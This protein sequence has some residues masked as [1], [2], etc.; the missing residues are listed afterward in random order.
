MS[1][2]NRAEPRSTTVTPLP[3]PAREVKRLKTVLLFGGSFD[4]PHAAHVAAAV[5]ARDRLFGEGGWVLFV[6]AARSPHKTSGTTAG[7]RERAEMVRL[8]VGDQPRCSVWT[9]ELDRANAAASRG[10]PAASYTIDTVRR[11]RRTLPSKI[12][13][14]VIIGAD[15]A[16][17]FHRWKDAR[18]LIALARPVVLPREP[19]AT[20]DALWNALQH[21]G[22]WKI[23]ELRAWCVYLAPTPVMAAS[24]TELRRAL[25]KASIARAVRLGLDRTVAEYIREHELYRAVSCGPSTR[26]R[27]RAERSA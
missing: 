26:R 19:I 14:R 24:S 3:I 4:P 15:H 20:P 18:K 12:E 7:D 27:S 9:D 16:A 10:R 17:A 22:F 21:A 23:E 1:L 8:A 5:L 11:L 13:I 25:A 6:P 2:R